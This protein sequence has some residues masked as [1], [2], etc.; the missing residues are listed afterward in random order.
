MS[1]LFEINNNEIVE[2]VI[3]GRNAITIRER[4][5]TNRHD[6]QPHNTAE[7]EHKGDRQAV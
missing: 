4:L 2:I 7:R 3:S 5:K 6:K 1:R